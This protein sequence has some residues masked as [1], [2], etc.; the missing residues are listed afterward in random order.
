MSISPSTYGDRRAI[1]RTSLGICMSE[2][3]R[4]ERAVGEKQG[5]VAGEGELLGAVIEGVAGQLRTRGHPHG[6]TRGAHS[7]GATAWAPQGPVDRGA[8]STLDVPRPLSKGV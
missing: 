1:Q 7:A 3:A 6:E 8:G 4:V 5:V 2:A